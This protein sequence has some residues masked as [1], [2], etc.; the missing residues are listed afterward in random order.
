MVAEALTLVG[1]FPYDS[2]VDTALGHRNLILVYDAVWGL[3]LAYVVYAISQWRM[4]SRN[5][6]RPES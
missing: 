6:K 4:L 5:E 3:H 1:F 2:A